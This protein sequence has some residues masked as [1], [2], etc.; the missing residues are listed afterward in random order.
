M[1][2]RGLTI[3]RKTTVYLRFNVDGNL[4]GNSK[5]KIKLILL[6]FMGPFKCYIIQ[7]G[8]RFPIK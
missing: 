3:N 4:D 1:E 6:P 5:K 8:V 2:D 7:W